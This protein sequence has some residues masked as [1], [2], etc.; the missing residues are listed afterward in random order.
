MDEGSRA[1]AIATLAVVADGD[2]PQVD[3]R[4][5]LRS[6]WQP[7]RAHGEIIEDRSVSFLE[8]FYDL[9]YVVVI[10]QAAH[11][12]AEHVT[13][14]GAAE[15][16]VVFGMIWL[17]WMNG[18]VYYDLHGREDGRTRTFVFIQMGLL[19]LLAVFTA[20]AVGA[21]G[22]AFAA[23]YAIYFAVF[24]WL[25]YTVRRQDDE[26]YEPL[27]RRYLFGMIVSTI[28][29][30]ATAFMGEE[31]RLIIWA[32]FVVGWVVGNIVLVR[33]QDGNAELEFNVTESMV[34]RAGLFTIIVL[35]EVVVGVVT[36]ISDSERTTIVIVTG[37]IGLAIGIA[38]WW[39][40]FDFVGGRAVRAG[41]GYG[42]QWMMGHL[43]A[44][45]AIAASGA[46]MVSLIEHAADD[47]TPAPTAWLLSGAVALGLLAL[48]AISSA[49]ADAERIPL[50]YGPLR[51]ALVVAAVAAIG[52]GAVR[53]TPWLFALLLVAVLSAVWFFAIKLWVLRTEPGEPIPSL[54]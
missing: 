17:A 47:R 20:D 8:L 48:V 31:L 36:G 2:T 42:A 21:D 13:W 14:R 50:V 15:F 46:A 12:L 5:F 28:V 49:L 11:H 33:L 26:R 3:R 54:D 7:P 40:Y 52:L 19:A 53:P 27:T 51:I 44:A 38:Y 16:A 41:R 23:V 30:A 18:T 25:W 22:P 6:Y 43:P 24:T 32:L 10:A 4:T 34:E 39:T 29:I 37:M 35:G 45:M 9:V 1:E